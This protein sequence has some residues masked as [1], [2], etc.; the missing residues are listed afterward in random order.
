MH[1]KPCQSV[2]KRQCSLSVRQAFC[3]GSFSLE[4]DV[5]VGSAQVAICFVGLFT[6][7]PCFFF[8]GFHASARHWSLVLSRLQT[9]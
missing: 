7:R 3:G 9:Q 5:A 8:H 2:R 4:K 1:R 6:S